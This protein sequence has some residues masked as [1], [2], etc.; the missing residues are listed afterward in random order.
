MCSHGARDNS[1]LRM[2]LLCEIPFPLV[3]S[4]SSL[5]FPSLSL[6]LPP[7]RTPSLSPSLPLHLRKTSTKSEVH[8]AANFFAMKVFEGSD[9]TVQPQTFTIHTWISGPQLAHIWPWPAAR[10][11]LAGSAL[12]TPRCRTP[13][14]RVPVHSSRKA[15]IPARAQGV[16]SSIFI[17]SSA[18][19]ACATISVGI[20]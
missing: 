12:G 17:S 13:P 6:R 2:T 8:G 19:F 20:G 1:E 3:M 10:N 14:T 4:P 5:L 18:C 15:P 16:L 11:A 9:E 7:S